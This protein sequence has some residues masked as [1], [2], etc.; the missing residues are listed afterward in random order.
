LG[1]TK[2]KK[3][4]SLVPQE[5]YLT[6]RMKKMWE[7]EHPVLPQYDVLHWGQQMDSSDMR[8]EY[9]VKLAQEINENYFKYDGFVIVHGTDTMAYTASAL[10][11]MLSGLGKPVILTGSM[12]PLEE[13][14]SDAR[15]NLITSIII[16]VAIGIPE[17]CIFFGDSLLRG[18]RAT[19]VAT[20][21]HDAFQSPNFPPLATTGVTITL[22]SEAL[23]APRKPL[24]LWTNLYNKIAVVRL[25]PGFDD[26]CIR[27]MFHEKTENPL[28]LVLQTYGTGNVPSK[29]TEFLDTIKFILEERNAVVI[30]LSQ[31]VKGFVNLKQYATGYSLYMLGVIDGKDMTVEACVTKLAYLMGRGL[32]GDELK[33]AME[34]N[35]R[36]EVGSLETSMDYS[37]QQSGL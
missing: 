8:P 13:P 16:S 5:G 27:S 14:V 19:K 2:D 10:S 23:P 30:I 36:G 17:V 18:N 11:F 24:S 4:G 1:M 21:T 25:V 6:W 26:Q 12:S 3:T 35:L 32:R 28:A 29:K 33:K 9:W 15:R 7:F 31:C 34:T 20:L 22:G 37:V